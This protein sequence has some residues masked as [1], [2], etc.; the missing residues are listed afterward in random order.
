MQR[1]SVPEAYF[2]E[3]QSHKQDSENDETR[4][5]N[6]KEVVHFPA[7]TVHDSSGPLLEQIAVGPAHHFTFRICFVIVMR[8]GADRGGSGG[9][10]FIQAI[11]QFLDQHKSRNSRGCSTS[12]CGRLD[13][14]SNAVPKE[15]GRVGR[16]VGHGRLLRSTASPMPSNNSQDS[17]QLPHL[18][19]SLTGTGHDRRLSHIRHE[20]VSAYP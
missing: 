11:G 1:S 18:P 4:D 10:L 19:P 2:C 8:P 20:F 6:G 7:A 15:C 9:L 13:S 5:I 17:C 16:L 3:E 12:T 14:G